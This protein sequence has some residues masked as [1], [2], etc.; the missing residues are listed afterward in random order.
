MICIHIY[1]DVC[2][3]ALSRA[4]LSREPVSFTHNKHIHIR[5]GPIFS[6]RWSASWPSWSCTKDTASNSAT[7]IPGLH[8]EGTSCRRRDKS[9]YIA[10]SSEV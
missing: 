7:P 9:L 4:C 1:V 2:S 8:L 10:E 3:T 6:G 5:S